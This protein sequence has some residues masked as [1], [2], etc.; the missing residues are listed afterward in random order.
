MD[1]MICEGGCG[2]TPEERATI[3]KHLLFSNR[4]L[5]F[6]QWPADREL[7]TFD[8]KSLKWVLAKEAAEHQAKRQMRRV[9]RAKR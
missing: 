8:Y 3:R 4:T 2:M 1:L 7:P 6:M 5:E 9:K